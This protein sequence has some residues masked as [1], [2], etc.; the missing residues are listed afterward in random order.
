MFFCV[1]FMQNME[2]DKDGTSSRLREYRLGFQKPPTS[3]A[4]PVKPKSNTRSAVATSSVASPAKKHIKTPCSVSVTLLLRDY[5]E[6]RITVRAQQIA[7]YWRRTVE[8]SSFEGAARIA[9]LLP[10]VFSC[11]TRRELLAAARFS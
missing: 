1:P 11:R 5:C 10:F 8:L 7:S 3:W 4:A 9:P 6:E 2:N